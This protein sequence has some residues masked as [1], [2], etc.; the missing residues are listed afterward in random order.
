MRSFIQCLLLRGGPTAV[1]RFV[2]AVVV[3]AINRKSIGPLAHVGKE[4][5]KRIPSSAYRNS[6]SS[7]V[8]KVLT[9]WIGASFNHS[10]PN[11]ISFGSNSI[12]GVA[13]TMKPPDNQFY[14]KASARPRVSRGKAYILDF[15]NFPATATA[16]AVG[17]LTAQG[18]ISDCG[19]SCE[20]A[21]D[22]G[23]SGR[24][25][26]GFIK[27]LFNGGRP[28]TTGARCDYITT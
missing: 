9:A 16:N 1:A 18:S 7:I 25:T 4:L 14:F 10:S 27:C 13:M 3:D 21:T 22:Q 26:F 2:V 15:N 8:L 17:F 28:A 6:P 23:Y 19:K 24:H 5:F 11:T 20:V 12:C